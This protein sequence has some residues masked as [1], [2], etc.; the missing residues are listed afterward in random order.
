M[1]RV[2]LIIVLGLSIQFGFSQHQI[3]SSN[4]PS[5]GDQYYF[6][7]CDT[8]G[9]GGGVDGN[10]VTW[11]YSGLNVSNDLDTVNYYTPS[12]TPYAAD[13]ST[14]T[15]GEE[16]NGQYLF[17]K[18]SSTEYINTGMVTA[19]FKVAY[20]DEAKIAD[21]PLSYG[22]SLT[23]SL[24]GSYSVT[25][26][27]FQREGVATSS[28]SGFGTLQLPENNHSNVAKIHIHQVLED[29][30]SILGTSTIVNTVIDSWTFSQQ[31]STEPLL[32]ISQVVS[33]AG[34][35]TTV[36]KIVWINSSLI[37]KSSELNNTLAVDFYPNPSTDNVTIKTKL[38]FADVVTV[39]VLD[40]SGKS[41]LKQILGAQSIGQVS[42]DVD[43]S[44]LETGMYLL[45][46]NTSKKS[47][48]DKLMI[49]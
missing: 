24:S 49:K 46:V 27:P 40:L 10:G 18:K 39:E 8:T 7:K 31:S 1:K 21:F 11:D 35:F 15:Y 20:T 5:V 4:L 33:D 32:V 14:S 16:N 12:S 34:G 26:V 42:T 28:Y 43:V 29:S 44:N 13:F 38:E 48:T 22:T 30:G 47:F 23:D 19:Q 6:R 3:A 37:K 2:L 25:G 41:V 36:D 45:K 9:V 17:Y